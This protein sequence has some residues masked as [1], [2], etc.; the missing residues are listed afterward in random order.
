MS[1]IFFLI[2]RYDSHLCFL[3][4]HVQCCTHRVTSTVTMFNSQQNHNKSDSLVNFLWLIIFLLIIISV[5]AIFINRG[6]PK[7]FV[8]VLFVQSSFLH[9][10]E[11]A[12]LFKLGYC[13]LRACIFKTDQYWATL[14]NE[15]GFSALYRAWNC[16]LRSWGSHFNMKNRYSLA[17]FLLLHNQ[18]LLGEKGRCW[19]MCNVLS[20][21]VQIQEW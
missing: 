6:V 5:T 20:Q 15:S 4:L 3:I 14:M 12:G 13:L 17:A 7:N 1:I 10:R 16:N 8:H 19:V 9:H 2:S 11:N 21:F 18:V